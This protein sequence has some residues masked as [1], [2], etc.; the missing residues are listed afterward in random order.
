MLALSV[1][2]PWGYYIIYGIPYAVS[3]DNGDGTTSIKDSGKV[4]LKDIENR[5]WALPPGFKLP[6]RI[7]IHI[8]K[9]FDPIEEVM[10]FCIGK[11]GLPWFS[12]ISSFS[13][14]L[15]RGAVIGEVDIVDC[16]RDSKSPWA[17]PGQHHFLL[18]N[19]KAYKTPIP[20]RGKLGFFE[21][22]IDTTKVVYA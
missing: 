11:L 10:D 1:R 15:P 8:S 13:N 18:A 20:C 2:P 4:I 3:V 17:V 16:V 7:Q 19:P 5:G 6:Q 21:P 12:I 22:D 9:T 14:N